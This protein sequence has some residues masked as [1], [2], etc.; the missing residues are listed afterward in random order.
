V[1]RVEIHHPL[2]FRR[3]RDFQGR[4]IFLLEGKADKAS[5]PL[6]PKF[7]GIEVKVDDDGDGRCR[8]VLTLGDQSDFEL[9]RVLCHDL[10]S[11]TARLAR[12]DNGRGLPVVLDR[13]AAWQDLLRRKNE[14]LL[15]KQEVIGLFGELLFL[16]DWFLPVIG[17][18]AVSAWR[19]PFGDEQD[20][21]HGDWIIEIK[22][23]LSTS[24]QRI[25]VSSE[26]Q[27]DTSSGKIF[28]CHQTLG[29]SSGNNPAARSLNEIVDE[30]RL[31][32][33]SNSGSL[34]NLDLAL[35]G[36][37]YVKRPEYDDG[38]W[39]LASRST[40]RVAGD[41]PRITPAMVMVGVEK[42]A[43]QIKIEACRPFEVETD[44]AMEQVFVGRS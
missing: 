31:A 2:D 32:L 23:Q 3:G 28:L 44:A 33:G 40:Y 12:G 21:V 30:I 17:Q 27:L 14:D 26:A 34:F 10:L 15:S 18:D 39:I 29:S 13:L 8:L 1:R 25:R 38:R 7:A 43:Y 42:V 36:S 4:Y 37:G 41:F 19:G 5:L 9:F 16:R 35:S 6:P 20:F 11:A 24:D 22:T